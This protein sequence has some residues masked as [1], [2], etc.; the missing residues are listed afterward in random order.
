M[1]PEQIQELIEYIKWLGD[2]VVTK[3]FELAMLEI[4]VQIV[5]ILLWLGIGLI[6]LIVAG[7]F[8]RLSQTYESTGS[9]DDGQSVRQVIAG[10]CAF[11]GVL[12]TILMSMDLIGFL[13]N[14]EWRAIE[15]IL[16]AMPRG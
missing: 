11:L 9:F 6:L 1:N 4:R 16:Q 14:P 12:L 15:L 5:Q 8:W 13:M 2:S 7:I 10:V 3:G